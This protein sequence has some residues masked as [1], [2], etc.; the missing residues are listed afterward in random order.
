MSPETE[1]LR[2][3]IEMT[4][5]TTAQNKQ[6]QLE[7]QSAVPGEVIHSAIRMVV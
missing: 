1:D 2:S 6:L 3:R 4:K 7:G 5:R